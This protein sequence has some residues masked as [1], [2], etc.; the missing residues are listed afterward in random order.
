MGGAGPDTGQLLLPALSRISSSTLKSMRAESSGRSRQTLVCIYAFRSLQTDAVVCH[1]SILLA[2]AVPISS[3]QLPR[4]SKN[5]RQQWGNRRCM[6]A[7]CHP[8]SSHAIPAVSSRCLAY[9]SRNSLPFRSAVSEVSHISH[10]GPETGL[11]A[12]KVMPV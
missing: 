5:V 11:T 12:R 3:A 1:F 8:L 4:N 7:H 9:S 10:K 2:Y 6:S